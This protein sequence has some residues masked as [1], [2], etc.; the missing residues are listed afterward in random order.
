[1]I[2]VNSSSSILSRERER[3]RE[4]WKKMEKETHIL[5]IP[6]PIQ[7]HINPMLQF[8]KRLASKGPRVTLLITSSISKSK[9]ALQHTSVNVDTI[10]DGSEEGET[11]E[12]LIANLDRFRLTVSQSLSEFIQKQNL[13]KH[14][15]CFIVYDCILPWVLNVAREHGLD[16]APF[17]T[18]SCAVNAIYYHLHRGAMRLP[19]EEPTVSLPSFPPLETSDLPSV[20]YRTGSYTALLDLALQQFSNIQQPNWLF[21]STFNELEPE[22]ST[23][24]M[25]PTYFLILSLILSL[26]YIYIGN[27]T[28]GY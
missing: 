28:K 7:G 2:V 20:I 19:F 14:P 11:V 3:E 18:Q 24:S 9:Q 27:F 1:L 22:V 21:F 6:Y 17:F 10:S 5:V 8:S 15:S 16:G 23:F 4:I 26:L 25:I 12:S 13:F